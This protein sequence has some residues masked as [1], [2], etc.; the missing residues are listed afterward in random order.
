MIP[1]SSF[2]QSGRIYDKSGEDSGDVSGRTFVKGVAG[3]AG[4]GQARMTN[5][6]ETRHTKTRRLRSNEG[7][8]H[9]ITH[10]YALFPS[11]RTGA[12]ETASLL[13]VGSIPTGASRSTIFIELVRMTGSSARYGLPYG[14]SATA[15]RPTR[16]LRAVISDGRALDEI[17]LWSP[18][19]RS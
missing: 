8:R 9:T 6:V 7:V 3:M 5:D 10:H 12:Q 4:A 2:L 19:R 13:F 18:I 17:P 14:E 15:R 16:A 1:D 11:D